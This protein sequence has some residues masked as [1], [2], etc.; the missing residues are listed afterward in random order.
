MLVNFKEQFVKVQSDI[1][2]ISLVTIDLGNDII[3]EVLTGLK[4]D[5]NI[6]V[7]GVIEV[8]EVKDN[9]LRGILRD[10]NY[11][12]TTEHFTDVYEAI[13]PKVFVTKEGQVLIETETFKQSAFMTANIQPLQS[14]FDFTL[15]NIYRITQ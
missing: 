12:S 11:K 15:N 1:D 7:E 5:E 4:I 14:F 6:L 2:G 8:T 10:F 3:A 9:V 13:N